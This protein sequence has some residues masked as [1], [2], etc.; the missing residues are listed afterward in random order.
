MTNIAEKA[1]ELAEE[2]FVT[3]EQ[4]AKGAIAY[5]SHD[6][7]RDMLRSEELYDEAHDDDELDWNCTASPAHY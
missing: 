4:I 2:G 6:D 3:W 7:L 1:Y 5:M